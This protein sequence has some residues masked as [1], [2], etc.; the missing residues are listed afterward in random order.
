MRTGLIGTFIKGGFVNVITDEFKRL[1]IT[2]AI[3][4]DDGSIDDTLDEGSIDAP[5]EDQLDDDVS[6]LDG[7]EN[8]ELSDCVS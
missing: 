5:A 8:I 1:F 2:E 4:D 3:V 7:A 6:S